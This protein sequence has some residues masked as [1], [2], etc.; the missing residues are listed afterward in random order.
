MA[1]TAAHLIDRVIPDVPI[2]QWVLSLPFALRYRVAFDTALLG[3]ILRVFIRAIFGSL[4]RH[5]RECGIPQG[6]CG[7]VT[8]IQRWGSA[9]NLTPHFHVVVFNGVYGQKTARLRA[10]T[11]C[12]RRRSRMGW[13]LRSGWLFGWRHCWIRG[14]TNRRI[15][16]SRDFRRFMAPR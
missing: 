15:G 10:S 16:M 7:A 9:L 5:A 8:F 2:R 4:R 3:Q 11:R 14:M 13:P 12:V 1:D 6:K